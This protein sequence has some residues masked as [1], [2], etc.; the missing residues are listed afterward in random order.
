MGAQRGGTE[1]MRTSGLLSPP[2]EVKA[3]A[4]T[5]GRS[6]GEK[7]PAARDST[8]M[9]LPRVETPRKSFLSAAASD[10]LAS[11]LIHACA[12][13]AIVTLILIFV[14]IGKEA[15]PVFTSAEVRE[16]AGLGN[17]FGSYEGR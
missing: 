11:V 14:F 16:E 6:D 10:K 7:K 5:P 4:E 1:G 3:D 8:G 15:L 9:R 2:E 17:L 12:S 13:L